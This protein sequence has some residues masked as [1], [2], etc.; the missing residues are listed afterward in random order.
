MF[1]VDDAIAAGSNLVSTI[2][3]KIWPD[4]N[5]EEKNKLTLALTEMQNEYNVILSQIDVNKESAKHG[6]IF[7]S[8]ARPFIL[9]V[10]GSALAYAALIEPLLQVIASFF[11][12]D[13]KFPDIN[14]D[15]TLQIL[16]GMLGLGGLRTAEKMK[17]VARKNLSE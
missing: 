8:G 16:L 5:L 17:N 14:T 3:N 11:G 1:G 15:I 12:A 13:I 7:V 4:A 2:V 9:W 6:Q 10:C